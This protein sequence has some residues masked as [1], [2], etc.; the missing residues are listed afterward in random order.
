MMMKKIEYSCFFVFLAILLNACT[1]EQA[2][3]FPKSS[4]ERLIGSLKENQNILTSAQ[5]GWAM[6]YFPTDAKAGYNFLMK[7]K[8][9]GE[10]TIAG[11][12]EYTLKNAFQQDSSLYQ[13]IADNGPVLTFNSFNAV[14]HVFS[15]PQSPN[16]YGMEGDYEFMILKSAENEIELKGKKRGV[17]IIMTPIPAN[18]TWPQYFD[19]LEAMNA[20]VLGNHPVPF[21]LT[22]PVSDYIFSN[23]TSRIF[24]I[25]KAGAEINTI[26]NASFIIT[27]TGIRFSTMQDIDGKKFQIM[28]LAEDK[29]ALVSAEDNSIKLLGPDSLAYYFW[30]DRNEWVVNPALLSTKLKSSYDA[31]VQSAIN[32]YKVDKVVLSV[33]Y[34]AARSSYVVVL[35]LTGGKNKY[36]GYNDISLSANTVNSIVSSEKGTGDRNG[37]TFY[38][39]LVGLSQMI[40]WLSGSFTIST[41][42][43][44]NP[45]DIK[46][47]QQ[48]D[49]DVWFT[50]SRQ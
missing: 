27:R 36:I 44:I 47:I 5:N 23:G 2:D 17:E 43:T 39:N 35:N 8:T 24:S 19:E 21:T 46:F 13:M 25:L 31:L 26:T 34:Y 16:G 20:T 48:Q 30:N 29:S 10:V 12:N 22:T 4:A 42:T 50:L 7:F 40:Q 41:N 28:N 38:S 32:K 11:K 6:Q 14:F 18:M 15:N 33:K 45:R 49:A 1:L 9:N 3:I 37:R